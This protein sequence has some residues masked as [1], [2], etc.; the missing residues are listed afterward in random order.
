MVSDFTVTV[1]PGEVVALVGR[2][3]AGKSTAL[4]AAVGLRY[5]QAG[6]R[7]T[8]DGSDVSQEPPNAMVVA[9]VEPGAR[10]PPDLPGHD[11]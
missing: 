8:I 6:G 1:E 2:N 5:G 7:C 3:G 11:A 10:G 4:A 9:G